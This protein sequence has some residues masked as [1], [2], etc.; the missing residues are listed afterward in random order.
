MGASFRRELKGSV[1][2][3]NLYTICIYIYIYTHTDLDIYIYTLYV[4]YRFGYTFMGASFFHE[5]VA[6]SA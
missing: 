2:V 4:L 3:P 1:Y 5:G 6:A